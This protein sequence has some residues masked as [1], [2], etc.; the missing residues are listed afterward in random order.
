MGTCIIYTRAHFLTL[1]CID[2]LVI[3]KSQIILFNSLCPASE[4]KSLVISHTHLSCIVQSISGCSD[5]DF[6]PA[7]TENTEPELSIKGE[8]TSAAIRNVAAC[9]FFSK[10]EKFCNV[11]PA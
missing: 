5:L 7:Q 3:Y 2:Y 4:G 11:S 1:I 8:G 9:I 6:F 10:V